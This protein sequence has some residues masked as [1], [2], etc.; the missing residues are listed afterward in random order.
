[1]GQKLPKVNLEYLAKT[2]RTTWKDLKNQD[3]GPLTDQRWTVK[4]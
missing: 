2:T 1:M 3:K 4:A